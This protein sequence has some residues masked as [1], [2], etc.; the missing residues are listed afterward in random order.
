MHKYQHSLS[1]T[2]PFCQL[3]YQLP[4]S[5]HSRG[6][7]HNDRVPSPALH[8]SV[9]G[10]SWQDVARPLGCVHKQQHIIYVYIYI[11]IYI[12]TVAL[13]NVENRLPQDWLS[14]GDVAWATNWILT[15]RNPI[16]WRN[17]EVGEWRCSSGWQLH[18]RSSRHGSLCSMSPAPRPIPS[19]RLMNCL[20]RLLCFA[21]INGGAVT[22]HKIISSHLRCIQILCKRLDWL[23]WQ[24]VASFL[25]TS[26]CLWIVYI[27]IYIYIH[28]CQDHTAV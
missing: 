24:S 13:A 6:T 21:K 20:K 9:N 3:Q 26:K 7:S 16:K 27:Y 1:T 5:L 4:L 28:G 14:G 12:Y 22:K 17:M 15:G 19:K 11:Y 10:Q 8:A 2:I 25:N 18:G 23:K